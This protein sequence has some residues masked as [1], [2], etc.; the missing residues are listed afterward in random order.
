ML[1]F[2][3]IKPG[4]NLGKTA[5]YYEGYVVGKESPNSPYRSTDEPPGKWYGNL[6][7][8]LGIDG[9]NVFHGEL[10]NALLGKTPDGSKYLTNNKA[11]NRKIG[12]DFVFSAPKSVSIAYALA[13][14]DLRK[15]ISEAHEK[16]VKAAIDY[17]INECAF[18][19]R[20]GKGG[21]I[22]ENAKDIMFALFEHA[23]NRANEPHLH[24]H[25]VL[26]NVTKSGKSIDFDAKLTHVIG[27]A[28][29]VELSRELSKYFELERD[30]QSFRIAGFD[31]S[32]E[33]LLSKRAHQIAERA[34]HTHFDSQKA[35]D[36]HQL[37]TKEDKLENP[38]SKSFEFAR[39]VANEVGFSLDSVLKREQTHEHAKERAFENA[40]KEIFSCFEHASTISDHYMKR[41]I[42]QSFQCSNLSIEDVTKEIDRIKSDDRIVEL[43]DEKSKSFRYTTKEMLDLEQQI[44]EFTKEAS[45]KVF[46]KHDD[47]IAKSVI[48][49][50]TLSDEQKNAFRVCTSEC[51]IAVVEGTAGAGKSYMLDAVREYYEKSGV[52]VFGCALA[53]KAAA[54]LEESAKIK[55]MTIHSLISNIE[56]QNI[57]IRDSVLVVDEAGMIGTKLAH[58]LFSLA[59]YA[60]AKVVLVGDTRQLQPVD[61]GA[62]MRICKEHAEYAEMNQIRRQKNDLDKDMVLALKNGDAN[63]A[64][65]I[66]KNRGYLHEHD[67]TKDIIKSVAEHVVSDLVNQKTSIALAARK[68][69][70]SLINETAREIAKQKGL[71]SKDEKEFCDLKFS[72]NDRVVTLR[73]DKRF[74]VKNGE[75]FTVVDCEKDKLVLLRDSDKKTITLNA[76]D[77]S[78][79]SH[80]Y[81]ITV[82]KAQGVTVDRAHV[83]HDS[84]MSS[85]SLS[86]VACSRHREAM[87]YHYTKA[88]AGFIKDEIARVK[89]NE[90]ASDFTKAEKIKEFFYKIKEKIS[91]AAH[92]LTNTLA[93]IQAAR[94]R[95]ELELERE[96]ARKRELER[97]RDYGD[98]GLSL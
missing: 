46:M 16:A 58:R 72:K 79:V 88:Q 13:D 22:R 68:K 90:N 44:K 8:E 70:V 77:Y 9:K 49:S 4:A 47:S 64:L 31:K 69:D 43:Y 3:R 11:D 45:E 85:R 92:A 5:R 25:C 78:A 73:N 50:R 74:N 6:A 36:I 26:P 14:E 28:Y 82:H 51:S 84:L 7:K 29:R 35:K 67:T 55:S 27:T 24:T 57:D 1:S 38:R 21:H 81:C 23:S 10:E 80:A 40:K 97:E 62:P 17:A 76:K 83:L 41:V 71:I 96:R 94:E 89:D 75:T 60:N 19:T 32:L 48:E 87:T 18:F 59:K 56:K 15:A 33:E 54:G 93:N 61:A 12:Y 66:M 65:F 39:Q 37:A 2:T 95:D 20:S 34:D 52:K 63:K 98:Y 30:N 91:S 86:Y 42:F 53:G